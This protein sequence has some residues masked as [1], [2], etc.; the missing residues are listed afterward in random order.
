MAI[1][2]NDL[3]S[4]GPDATVSLDDISSFLIS[5]NYAPSSRQV[6]HFFCRLDR[7]GTGVP[8]LKDWK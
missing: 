4:E 1:A 5:R 6:Q 2:V 8:K 3:A 7:Y